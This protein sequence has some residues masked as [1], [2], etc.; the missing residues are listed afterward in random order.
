LTTTQE[1][2]EPLTIP[3][4]VTNAGPVS[5]WVVVQEFTGSF[6]E[7]DAFIARFTAEFTAQKLDASLLSFHP[8]SILV[9]NEDPSS[10][11][12]PRMAVGLTVP[13]FLQVKEP[14]TAKR[15]Q[16]SMA[17]TFIHTG[18]YEELGNVHGSLAEAVRQSRPSVQGAERRAGWP[19]VLG[20][21]N[22][23]KTVQPSEIQTE[24]I[25]PVDETQAG[26]QVGE[27]AAIRKAV[28]E[29]QPVSF[30]L[31]AQ[32]F[33]GSMAQ[34]SDFI[35]TFMNEFTAQ[36]LSGALPG[37]GVVPLVILREDPG[38]GKNIAIE[39]GFPVKERVQV[40]APLSVQE[41]AFK[42]AVAY[43]HRG[44]YSRLSLAHKGIA[45]TVSRELR[46]LAGS[47]ARTSWPIALRPITDPTTVQSSAEI[48]TDII[49][50]IGD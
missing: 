30:L 18:P 16:F 24:V 3:N 34:V 33:N 50:P 31:V 42:K 38:T 27:L 36:G 49:V 6:Q 21:L 26:L 32:A 5:F 37:P 43:R 8:K 9:L 47:Q 23:P 20:L 2:G 13:G 45:D 12:K 41:F 44:D 15:L 46:T 29:A 19:V 4:A 7:V 1:P 28:H 39:V 25:V 22:D 11:A 10:T 48:N 35:R 14:L 40:R 17:V